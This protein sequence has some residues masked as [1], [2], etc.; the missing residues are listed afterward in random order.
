MIRGGYQKVL[1]LGGQGKCPK[2]VKVYLSPAAGEISNRMS[3][4][5]TVFSYIQVI[6]GI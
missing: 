5:S 4:K 2:K 1:G 3:G 6:G